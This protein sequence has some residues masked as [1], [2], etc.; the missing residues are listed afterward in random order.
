MHNNET[1]SGDALDIAADVIKLL[2]PVLKHATKGQVAELK[3]KSREVQAV[4]RRMLDGQKPVP[5]HSW[6]S[7]SFKIVNRTGL[8]FERNLCFEIEAVAMGGYPDTFHVT[9]IIPGMEVPLWSHKLFKPIN[10]LG[11]HRDGFVSLHSALAVKSVAQALKLRDKVQ[12]SLVVESMSVLF[13]QAP[14]GEDLYG[15][16][17]KIDDSGYKCT[18]YFKSVNLKPL[19]KGS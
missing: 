17:V 13:F 10:W 1:T 12:S 16:H 3:R 2:A 8:E 11:G 4:F 5:D 7:R 9:V 14:E 15:I 6:P 18:D 19:L